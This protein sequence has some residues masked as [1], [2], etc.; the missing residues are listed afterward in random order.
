METSG[1]V[2]CEPAEAVPGIYDPARRDTMLL[3]PLNA[4]IDDEQI[5]AAVRELNTDALL[6]LRTLRLLQFKNLVTPARSCAFEIGLRT[7]GQDTIAFDERESDLEIASLLPATSTEESDYSE[8]RRYLAAGP[9]SG[10]ARRQR[11]TGPYHQPRPGG[12]SRGA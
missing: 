6:F 5:A 10:M 9:V 8:F 12:A 2:A 4:E 7:T 1:P 11:G 3:L